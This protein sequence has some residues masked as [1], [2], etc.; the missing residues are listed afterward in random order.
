MPQSTDRL[1]RLA[2]STINYK[3]FGDPSGLQGFVDA[4]ELLKELC[5]P[6]NT[7]TLVRY[8]VT[9]LD[10]K[11]REAIRIPPV[12]P[13]DI[14]NQLKAVIKTDSSKVIESQILALKSD[15]MNLS[16]FAE[17]AEKLAETY[18]RSLCDEGYSIEKAK[19]VS[20]QKTVEL[21]RRNI[22]NGHV[23]SIIASKEFREPKDAIA[24]MII[25]PNNLKL[26]RPHTQNTRK[27]SNH[28]NGNGNG[29][30]NSGHKFHKNY[31]R[32]TNSD[33]N[34]DRNNH[35]GRQNGNCNGNGNRPNW[36]NNGN[37]NGQ[38]N[39]NSRTFTNSNYRRPNEQP[40]RLVSGN[41]MNPGNGG[42]ASEQQQ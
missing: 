9:K 14:I 16:T 30:G 34:D 17:R 38:S 20:V 28:K 33:F 15:K 24:A 37:R 42:Q 19:E 13:D 27:F 39:Q 5:E 26:L 31:N 11:A 36:N 22:K 12:T 8:L 29:N 21:S 41:E 1:M 6:Q 3:Y 4:I 10:G 32:N 25:E 35:N 40:V 23:D 18:R 2:I 7:T